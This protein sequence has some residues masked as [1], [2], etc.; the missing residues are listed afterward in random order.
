MP[1]FNQTAV[2]ESSLQRSWSRSNFM[3]LVAILQGIVAKQW[4][5]YANLDHHDGYLASMSAPL[6]AARGGI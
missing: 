1:Q 3:C 6:V 4:S 2:V 5:T